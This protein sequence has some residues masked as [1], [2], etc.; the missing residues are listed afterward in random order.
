MNSSLNCERTL[1]QNVA[2]FGKLSKARKYKN[3]NKIA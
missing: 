2:H 1:S 3:V